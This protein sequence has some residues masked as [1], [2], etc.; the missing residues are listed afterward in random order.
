LREWDT[1][2]AGGYNPALNFPI[3]PPSVTGLEANVSRHKYDPPVL[4]Q[5]RVQ[6]PQM[7][8]ALSPER[9]GR[10]P[11][12]PEGEGGRP[13]ILAVATE[14]RSG[15]GGLST[16]NRRLCRALAS[17]GARV[18][19]VVL[20]AS[21][22]ERDEAETDGVTLVEATRTP[23][24][25]EFALARRPELPAGFEPD[26]VIGHGRVTGPAAQVLA[27]EHFPSAKRLH[28]IHMAPDEIEWLKPD[29][30]D[31]A[32]VRAEER[33]QIELKLGRTAARV[34]TVGP[35]LNKRFLN[36]LSV[37]DIPPPI[38][39]D[40]GFD[41]DGTDPREPPPGAPL[42][43]LLLGRLEDGPIK[44][45]D[46]AAKAVGRA[47]G[48]RGE[49]AAPIELVVRGALPDTSAE[50]RVRLREWAGLPSL[51]VVVRPYTTDTER[52]D[53][54]LGRA[55]LVLMPSRS[56]GFGLVGLEAIT[57]GA[58]V[59]VSNESGLAD[60][61]REVLEYE[62]ASR[63]VV[64]MSGNEN[65]VVERWGRVIEATLRDRDAAFRRAAE[66]RASLGRQKTWAAA[67]DHLLSA[68]KQ[69]LVETV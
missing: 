40:P 53:A 55:S 57:A 24:Q 49:H 60:L 63:F 8:A 56:E 13:R 51:G 7:S 39:L 2:T 32:G 38:R 36:E 29:R 18:V 45:L 47:V 27:D 5:H 23:G 15:H 52:L 64:Q 19:C 61:L 4:P 9:E 31:D 21:Q 43:V 62:Q 59:L 12:T 14:W 44:G 50:L 22:E 35:R 58:P 48:W 26:I 11:A 30:G 46:L 28:F 25:E 17:A 33:T 41:S 10:R 3:L 37:Y 67:A 1:D 6:P 16:L 34:V 66:L 65:E 42:K 69:T 68:I 54:D 20:R